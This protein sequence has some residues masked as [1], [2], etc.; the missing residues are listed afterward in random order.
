[1]YLSPDLGASTP[2]EEAT[3]D[4]LMDALKRI[5]ADDDVTSA[6]PELA[7]RFPP[8]ERADPVAELAITPGLG[9]GRGLFGGSNAWIS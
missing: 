7:A 5:E 1:M 2:L 6:S 3:S 4:V 9:S 8:P